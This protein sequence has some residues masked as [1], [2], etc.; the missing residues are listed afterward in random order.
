MNKIGRNDLCP[1]GSGQKYKKCCL[2]K[3]EQFE[4]RRREEHQAIMTAL[5]WLY[6]TYTEEAAAEVHYDFMDEPD[7]ERVA[8]IGALSEHLENALDVNIGEWLLADAQIIVNGQEVAASELILGKGGP[9]LTP[10]GREWLRE[11]A[12]RPLALYEVR[13]VVKEKGLILADMLHPELPPV[14]IR[15]K[16]VSKFLRPWDTFGARLL[17]QDDSF[18]MSGAVYPM[19]REAALDC[20]A[21]MTS[22]LEYENGDATLERSITASTIIDYWLDSLLETRPL[23]ELVDAGSGEKIHLT[24]DHYRGADWPEFDKPESA[25]PQEVQRQILHQYL[26]KHYESWPE[27]ALPALNGKSP[28]AAVKDEELRPAVIELLKSIDQCEAGRIDESGGEP[29]DVSFLW[30]RLGVERK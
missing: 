9:L 28:L 1:C 21:E 19:D 5:D 29:F 4:S 24:T 25:I 11:L 13:E 20:L 27:I 30:T 22:E 6:A 16:A 7:E 2:A 3:N 23:P 10:H 18:V 15:E 12:K 14:E 8:A 17:W 26:A